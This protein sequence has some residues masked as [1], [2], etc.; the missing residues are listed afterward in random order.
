M[1]RIIS[2]SFIIP[3]SRDISTETVTQLTDRN[4][5]MTQKLELCDKVFK[6]AVIKNNS[7]R[8]CEHSRKEKKSL[9]E[10][11][12]DLKNQTD[13]LELKNTISEI[14]N[15]KDGLHSRGKK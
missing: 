15:S 3:R 11:T 5:E 4:P 2:K 1:S 7:T 6:V 13:V 14:S 10:E 9:S 12:D 8:N